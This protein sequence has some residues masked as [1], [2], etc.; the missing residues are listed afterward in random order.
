M[1]MAHSTSKM[2]QVDRLVQD[3]W[4]ILREYF[5]YSS[6]RSGQEEL[7]DGLLAG[8][9]VFGLMPTGA[10]KSLCYQVPA[11]VMDGVSLVISPL[12]SLMKDQVSALIQSGVK[13][14]YLNSSL[15]PGQFRLALERASQGWYKIIYVAPERLLTESFARVAERLPISLVAVDEAHCVSQWGQDFRPSYLKIREFLESLPQRPPVGAFTATATAQVRRDIVELL[16]LREPVSVCTGFDRPNLR[17]EVKKPADKFAALVSL[18]RQEK[19][20][21]VIVYCLTRRTVEEVCER[22]CREGFPAVRYHAGLTDEERRENQDAFLYDKVSVMVAT[23]AFGMGIDKSNVSMVIHYNMPKN[24]EGYY[25]AAGRAGRD[26]S[27]ARCVLLYS[28]QDVVTNRLLIE[29]SSGENEELDEEQRERVRKQEEERLKKMTFYCF[30]SDCLRA[31]LLRYFGEQAPRRCENC[32]TCLQGGEER[33][34]TREMNLL[35]SCV[36]A[37]G[38]GYGK[39]TVAALL[40]GG[41]AAAANDTIRRRCLDQLPQYGALSGFSVGEILTLID[42]AIGHGLLEV[43]E[44][45]YPLLALTQTGES[46]L[47]NG[48]QISMRMPERET[49]RVSSEKRKPSARIREEEMTER[50]E[51]YEKLRALRARLAARAGVP[52]YVVFTDRALREMAGLLP[53]NEQELLAVNGVGRARLERYGGEFLRILNEYEQEHGKNS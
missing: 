29:R 53:L 51:L 1:L 25:Q 22:L 10:G 49:A 52:A 9:D 41:A 12:I 50:P 2:K 39:K 26:G 6:F 28:G 31:Y 4:Q 46:F 47:Q 40:A 34:M 15:T 16:D 8:R 7:V 24:M 48:E 30:T 43:T 20:Q 5:G 37:C 33:D 13:A 44:G 17:F 19:G 14:A 27:P 3:K 11:L 21:S 42:H 45:D 23:N 18:L 36:R 38:R 32:S 35:L